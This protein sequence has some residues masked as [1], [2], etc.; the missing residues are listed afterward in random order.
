MARAVTIGNFDGVHLGHQALLRRLGQTASE[1]GL[2]TCALTFEPHPREYFAAQGLGS[3]P[4]RISHGRNQWLALRATGIEE[5]GLLR[6]GPKIASLS[7]RQFV[8]EILIKG[9]KTRYLL[10]GD[11]FRFGKGRD[12]DFEALKAM[13]PELGLQVEA[14]HT[15]TTDQGRRISSTAVRQA[16]AEGDFDHAA[17]LLGRHYQVAGHVLHGRKLGRELG[18]PT[19][20]FSMGNHRPALHG[21]YVVSVHGLGPGRLPGVASLGTRPVV[22]T[23]GRYLLEVHLFN[24]QGNA[25]GRLLGVEFHHKLRNELHY[26]GLDALRAQIQLDVQAARAWFDKQSL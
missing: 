19:L 14:I 1:R 24:W 12:G 3:A 26:Q 5:L 20:N 16:L 22:E 2:S 6:F 4:T 21:V 18:F 11:D 17:K 15:V 10:I 23:N 8:E 25:Y 9:L 13:S 7:A